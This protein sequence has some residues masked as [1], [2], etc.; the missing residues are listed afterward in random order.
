MVNCVVC[1]HP[2][3]LAVCFII[4]S[5]MVV[6]ASSAADMVFEL[7]VETTVPR[8]DDILEV[9]GTKYVVEK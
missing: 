9:K 8:D 7:D 4:Y 6:A 3:S 5:V 1:E 2:L